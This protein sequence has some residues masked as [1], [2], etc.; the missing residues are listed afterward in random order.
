M[1][2][3]TMRRRHL[4]V[5]FLLLGTSFS[6]SSS[7]GVATGQSTMAKTDDIRS[8]QRTDIPPRP[9]G[10]FVAWSL[11]TDTARTAAT[12]LLGFTSDTWNDPTIRAPVELLDYESLTPAQ[13][14]GASL[15]MGIAQEAAAA[16]TTSADIWDCWINHYENYDWSEMDATGANVQAWWEA[17][18]WTAASWEGTAAAPAS[19]DLDWDSLTPAEQQAATFLC[20]DQPQWDGVNLEDLV[21]VA[22]TLAPITVSPTF[23]GQTRNPTVVPTSMPTGLP[24]VMPTMGPTFEGQTRVPT[25]TPVTSPPTV[26]PTAPPTAMYSAPPAVPTRY[27]PFAALSANIQGVLQTDLGYTEATWNVPGTNNLES[28]AFDSLPAP[29]QTAITDTLQ[30]TDDQWD[31][32]I[33][34]FDDYN[35]VELNQAGVQQYWVALGWSQTSWEGIAPA[36]ASEE[37]EWGAL[38]ASEKTAAEMLCYFEELWNGL[39]L[40][41]GSTASPT[42]APD[43]TR[44]ISSAWMERGG[45]LWTVTICSLFLS[46]GMYMG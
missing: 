17:L 35:W 31:C 13:I 46:I 40:S 14:N 43:S 16:T 44:D 2:F 38:T 3:D 30:W 45:G 8:L 34:H 23:D 7:T 42:A 37:K 33:N 21:T 12:D 20:Y 10:R 11:L 9:N 27:Q 5:R 15:A 24:T 28:N 39:D 1:T 4:V 29:Q 6:L 41:A 18:G 19:D 26:A 32:H 36:P 22:P 25:A